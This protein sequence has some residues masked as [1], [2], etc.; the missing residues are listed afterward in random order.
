[1]MDEQAFT[2]KYW[3]KNT[4]IVEVLNPR[5]VD[6]VFQ[7]TVDTGIDVSTGR[8]KAEARRYMV[9][10]GG[11]ERFPGPI[12]N[13]YLDQMSRILAQEDN[14][15]DRMIDPSERAKYYDQLIVGTDDLISSYNELPQYAGIG[16][17]TEDAAPKEEAF[18]SVKQPKAKV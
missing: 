6:Y 17:K 3:K 1:M 18:A 15:F 4:E 16:E 7:A 8:M 2:D 11:S 14:R 13:M 9:K 12:A 5:T 10:A